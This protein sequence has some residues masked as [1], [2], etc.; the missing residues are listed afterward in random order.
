PHLPLLALVAHHPTRMM[1][2][3]ALA[4]SSPCGLGLRQ[5]PASSCPVTPGQAGPD[6]TMS[7][8]LVPGNDV[9]GV[10]RTSEG[11]RSSA[12]EIGR[13]AIDCDRILI[14]PQRVRTAREPPPR[15]AAPAQEPEKHTEHDLRTGHSVVAALV[16]F[17]R[18]WPP[19]WSAQVAPRG[20][21]AAGHVRGTALGHT[22]V[23]SQAFA[24]LRR[25]RISPPSGGSARCASYGPPVT[26]PVSAAD[27]RPGARF[28]PPAPTRTCTTP[29]RATTS[30]RDQNSRES[31]TSLPH[32][33]TT[34]PSTPP[35]TR[36]H[37]ALVVDHR[38]A[39]PTGPS[40]MAAP[41]VSRPPETHVRTAAPGALDPVNHPPAPT[42]TPTHN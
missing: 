8:T 17:P 37:T 19:R 33:R 5:R 40:A 13:R 35:A 12:S 39:P 23:V 30:T 11:Q 10:P 32:S 15:R 20:C 42:I 28:P 6:M 1:D 24:S 3:R 2:S 27:T 41:A 26:A 7:A 31:E 4:S 9:I 22:A 38:P 34:V 14:S 18:P 16:T 29:S 36:S 25:L 21:G